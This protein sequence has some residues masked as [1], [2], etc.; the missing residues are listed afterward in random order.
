MTSNANDV[1]LVDLDGALLRGNSFHMWLKYVVAGGLG[2]VRPSPRWRCRLAVLM[3]SAMRLS[4]LLDHAA[5]KRRVQKAW[6]A[7]MAGSRDPSRE[8]G[9][10][11]AVLDAR[12]DKGLLA[13]IRE[14]QANRA[15]AVL[16]TA[17][18]AE[19]AEVLAGDLGFDAV[20]ATPRGG[21]VHW[22]HN[23]GAVKCRR[24]LALLEERKWHDRRRILYTD[25]LDD[26]P[27]MAESQQI[28]LVAE[29]S[30]GAARALASTPEEKDVRVYLRKNGMRK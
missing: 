29:D 14:A 8:L 18:A 26:L 24:T 16:T 28:H 6:A 7:A 13:R 10:F 30:V 17:A 21:C 5:W 1:L 23:I 15:V 4:R 27:L 22:R 3:F 2:T 19:Y 11:L 20:V 9:G 12:I 25:H